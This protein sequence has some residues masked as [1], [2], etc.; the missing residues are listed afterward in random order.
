M[1]KKIP[2]DSQNDYSKEIVQARQDFFSEHSGKPLEHLKYFSFD[3]ANAQG[4]IE[5]FT[6]VAQVPLGFA[7]PLLVNGEHARGEFYV[8]MATTEGTLVAS[9][10]RGMRLAHDLGGVTV[11]VADD[12]MQRA[13]VFGFENARQAKQ[14]AHWIK[15]TLAA[16][17]WIQE[18]YLKVGKI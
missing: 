9:Y 5:H 10:N 6:G 2:R 14:F 12:A 8:P 11:T 1:T 15:D 7:G 4:N 3:P 18:E 17:K 16:C 13:P